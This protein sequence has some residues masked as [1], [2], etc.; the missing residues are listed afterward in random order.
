MAMDKLVLASLRALLKSLSKNGVSYADG[1]TYE[2]WTRLQT[3]AHPYP[4]L[5]PTLKTALRQIEPVC[6]DGV[7][8][9]P[10]KA[11]HAS[12]EWQDCVYLARAS[13]WYPVWGIWPDEDSGKRELRLEEVHDLQESPS[14]LPARFAN[15]LYRQ[16][17]SGMGYTLFEVEFA[18]G[19]RIA[20]DNGNAIDFLAYP[21]GKSGRDIVAVQA[22]TGR[23][24]PH[25]FPSPEY[26][27]CL[28]SGSVD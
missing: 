27:W 9:W 28:F 21:P 25:P 20:F 1:F 13:E 7:T 24:S 4:E 15:E 2:D 6:G 11:L 17:E 22:H 19:S 23:N 12:G 10:C 8:Y 3:A 18:D 14:R 16:G 26:V 5:T